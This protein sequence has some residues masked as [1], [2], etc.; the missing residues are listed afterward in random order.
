MVGLLRA[1]A[2]DDRQSAARGAARGPSTWRRRSDPSTATAR[3]PQ[4]LCW[5]LCGVDDAPDPRCMRLLQDS[6]SAGRGRVR[7]AK[8][9]RAAYRGGWAIPSRPRDR[10]LA[11]WLP[12]ALDYIVTQLLNF[13][14]RLDRAPVCVRPPSAGGA[15]KS[16]WSGPSA[17]PRSRRPRGSDAAVNP[18]SRVAS[19]GRPVTR[20][21][22]PE[23][24]REEAEAEAW[25]IRP[26]PCPEG[27]NPCPGAAIHPAQLLSHSRRAL[28]APLTRCTDAPVPTLMGQGR[29]VPGRARLR[30]ALARPARSMPNPRFNILQ[31]NASA[32]SCLVIER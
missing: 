3:Q 7:G 26:A 10:P 32:S 5:A 31:R 8:R 28:L 11:K 29:P 24:S 1:T 20:R 27:R 16:C 17:P 13:Q 4:G 30:A 19:P 6:P 12:A 21:R 9:S 25:T 22:H 2:L 15:R 18:L 14:L 23:A